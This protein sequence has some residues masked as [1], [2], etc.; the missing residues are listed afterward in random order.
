M[1]FYV[2]A[3]KFTSKTMNH[4]GPCCFGNNN[5]P[6]LPSPHSDQ[7]SFLP[8]HK[9]NSQNVEKQGN[10]MRCNGTL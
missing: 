1:L 5:W 9:K 7:L 8:I 2:F 6:I 3:L 10:K 4:D